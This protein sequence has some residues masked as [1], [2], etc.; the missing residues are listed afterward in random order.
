MKTKKYT[1]WNK[2]EYKL[3]YEYCTKYKNDL[4]NTL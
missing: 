1:K 3:M 4:E 2:S